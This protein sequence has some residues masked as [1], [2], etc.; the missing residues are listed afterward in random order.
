MRTFFKLLLFIRIRARWHRSNFSVP[1]AQ[2]LK[3]HPDVGFAPLN[4]DHPF[5]FLG[6][7][8][9]AGNGILVETLGF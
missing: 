9:T 7:F 8:F 5:Y 3:E 2:F 6:G 1:H 4:A